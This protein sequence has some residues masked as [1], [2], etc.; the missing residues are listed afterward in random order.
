MFWITVIFIQNKRGIF[1]NYY[2]ANG[3]IK[4]RKVNY[5]FKFICIR[6]IFKG[7]LE[8]LYFSRPIVTIFSVTQK[9]S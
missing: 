6:S 8:N 1:Y 7:M 5:Y 9:S 4:V 2:V 3:G